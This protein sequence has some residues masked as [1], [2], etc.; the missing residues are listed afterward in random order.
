M[1]DDTSKHRLHEALATPLV[2]TLDIMK[3]F[4]NLHNYIG[5]G[6][7]SLPKHTVLVIRKKLWKE[8]H[9]QSWQL[10]TFVTF[11]HCRPWFSYLKL[12]MYVTQR[13]NTNVDHTVHPHN[14]LL[15]PLTFKTKTYV[16]YCISK[17]VSTSVLWFSFIFVKFLCEGNVLGDTITPVMNYHSGPA[18]RAL[19]WPENAHPW[20]AALGTSQGGLVYTT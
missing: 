10:N 15:L 8:I 16:F 13:W 7:S 2:I 12:P 4:N 11:M 19:S 3:I 5:L 1:E 17:Q 14:S 18:G 20:R 6:H 9:A